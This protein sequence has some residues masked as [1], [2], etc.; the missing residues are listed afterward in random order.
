MGLSRR[1]LDFYQGNVCRL[2]RSRCGRTGRG[3]AEGCVRS[4]SGRIVCDDVLANHLYFHKVLPAVF[5]GKPLAT[6]M[7]LVVVVI[8]SLA[9]I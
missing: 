4:V 9:N 3:K 8:V 7:A 6:E 2:C 1:V 5:A